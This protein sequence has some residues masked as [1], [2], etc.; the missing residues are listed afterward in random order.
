[1]N[2]GGEPAELDVSMPMPNSPAVTP[3]LYIRLIHAQCPNN[4]AGP[5]VALPNHNGG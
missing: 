1:M 2:K 5:M 4:T 3:G